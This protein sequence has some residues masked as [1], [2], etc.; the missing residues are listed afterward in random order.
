MG[1]D[2]RTRSRWQQSGRQQQA[3]QSSSSSRAAAAAQSVVETDLGIRV[4]VSEV[5]SGHPFY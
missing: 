5:E 1:R 4:L 3:E 2:E